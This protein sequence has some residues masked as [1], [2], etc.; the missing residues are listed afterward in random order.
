MSN[1]DPSIFE[2]GES[3]ALKRAIAHFKPG[4]HT[5]IPSGDDAAVIRS[6]GRYVVT[7]DTMVQ[8]RDFLLK[9]SS[10]QNLGYKAVATNLSDVVAMGAKPTSLVVALVVP[11]TTSVSFLENFARGLQSGI[12][13]LFP[14]CEVVGGDLASGTE[15]VIAVTAHGEL[16]QEPVLRSGAKVGDLVV[17]AGTLGKAAA[18]LSLLLAPDHTLAASY[19]ELVEV[20]LAPKPPLALGLELAGI[21]N[22]MLDLSDGLSTDAA[23]IAKASDVSIRLNSS[24]LI[25]YEAVLELAAQSM[26]AR[27]FEAAETDWVLH[28]GEDHSFLATVPAGTLLPKGCKVIGEVVSKSAEPVYLDDTPLIAKGWDS[29]SS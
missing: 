19:P 23:R 16:D 1:S 22:S 4:S 29:I 6:G 2:L 27:G 11:K 15:I 9:Y 25:G 18:G 20:Q 3:E 21:A 5:L 8:D 7:T 14:G 17:V 13:E 12:D 24:A 10:A 26:T 28:G